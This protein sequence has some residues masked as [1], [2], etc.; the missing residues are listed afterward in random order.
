MKCP[1]QKR[2]PWHNGRAN[3]AFLGG[4]VAA[5]GAEGNCVLAKAWWGLRHHPRGHWRHHELMVC[6][7]AP[8]S[9]V[10]VGL[11]FWLGIISPC[12]AGRCP[13]AVAV[14]AVEVVRG[15]VV[16]KGQND[17]GQ[18]LD[19]CD[20]WLWQ[21]QPEFCTVVQSASAGGQGV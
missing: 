15:M 18:E 8:G 12:N 20:H 16:S 19:G 10:F 13:S 3:V 9:G 1:L 7:K 21:I 2:I 5:Q 4:H 6:R 11:R 14:R 17:D